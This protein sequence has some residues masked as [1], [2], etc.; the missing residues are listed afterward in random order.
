M[1]Y[2]EQLD[3]FVSHGV[4]YECERLTFINEHLPRNAEAW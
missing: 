1:L 2:C 3:W 4:K